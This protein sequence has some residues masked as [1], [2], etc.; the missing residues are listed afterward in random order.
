MIKRGVLILFEEF[1]RSALVRIDLAEGVPIDAFSDCAILNGPLPFTVF[2]KKT[3]P[4]VR[5]D[6][7]VGFVVGTPRYIKNPEKN[8]LKG[9]GEGYYVYII[10]HWDHYKEVERLVDRGYCLQNTFLPNDEGK[11]QLTPESRFLRFTTASFAQQGVADITK[12]PWASLR[13]QPYKKYGFEA[14]DVDYR[15]KTPQAQLGVWVAKGLRRL[16]EKKNA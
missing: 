11:P 7:V 13:Y 6:E 10:I 4:N 16:K 3:I 12:G 14:T 9:W 8:G 1:D 5:T 2:D 15:K